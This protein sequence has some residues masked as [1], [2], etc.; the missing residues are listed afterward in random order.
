MKNFA[1]RMECKGKKNVFSY[2]TNWV[3]FSPYFAIWKITDNLQGL[4]TFDV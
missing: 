4:Q 1:A 2:L 3:Q